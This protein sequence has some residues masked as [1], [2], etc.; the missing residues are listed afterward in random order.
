MIDF[1]NSK[2]RQY[3]CILFAW[4]S[5][6]LTQKSSPHAPLRCFYVFF[7][8]HIFL[9]SHHY[10]FSCFYGFQKVHHLI[11]PR[12]VSSPEITNETQSRSIHMHGCNCNWGINGGRKGYLN[13]SSNWVYSLFSI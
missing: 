6:F 12:S 3:S 1:F 2:D 5:Q 9:L 4:N 11:C 10:A 7:Q 13:G 8:C